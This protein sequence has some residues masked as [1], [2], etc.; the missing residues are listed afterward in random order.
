[1]SDPAEGAAQRAWDSTEGR[2]VSVQRVAAAREA[3]NP[4]RELHHPIREKWGL[5]GEAD[6]CA[7]CL[8]TDRN[9]RRFHDLWPCD[10]ARLVYTT[11]E[12]HGGKP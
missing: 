2:P 1:M 3:M 4:V 6:V 9:G 8:L 7:H 12:I 10:T 5:G 11:E